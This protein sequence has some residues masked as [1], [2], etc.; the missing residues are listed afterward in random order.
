M[1]RYVLLKR[2]L[3]ECP[4]HMGYTGIRDKAGVWDEEYVK[5]FEF[6]ILDKY[7]PTEKDSYSIPFYLAPEFTK[8]SFH[9][10]NEAHLRSRIDALQ[11]ENGRLRAELERLSDKDLS[12]TVT[13]MREAA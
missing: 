8:T 11:Q 6:R 5:R 3:Y 2:D 12:R 9:D 1:T 13:E 10:L 7:T 4:Q